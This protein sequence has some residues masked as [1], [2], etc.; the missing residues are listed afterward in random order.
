MEHCAVWP[1]CLLIDGQL[2][3][4]SFQSEDDRNFSVAR[5]TL[6]KVSSARVEIQCEKNA[7]QTIRRRVSSP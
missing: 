3:S 4:G 6:P 5:K 1:A 7:P 2:N